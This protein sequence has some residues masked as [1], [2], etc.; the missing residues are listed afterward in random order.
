MFIGG[1]VLLLGASLF[2]ALNDLVTRRVAALRASAELN[3]HLNQRYELAHSL[4]ESVG[5][6]AAHERP[7]LE[8]VLDA[9]RAATLAE[10][11]R[12]RA[13]AEA[14]LT[15]AL[16]VP[17]A[18]AEAYPELRSN[19]RFVEVQQALAATEQAID[20]A[21]RRFNRL[22]LA[23]NAALDRPPASLVAIGLGYRPIEIF[24]LT[25]ANTGAEPAPTPADPP[26]PATR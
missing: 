14:T 18:M 15:T 8:R 16:R 1:L 21:M 3:S 20:D 17:T 26:R 10:Q 2:F 19:V 5:V 22:A 9:V 6:Y 24:P 11:P 25:V 4:V 13:E 23:Y 12:E 7:L